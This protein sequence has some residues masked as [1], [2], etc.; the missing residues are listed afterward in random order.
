[1]PLPAALGTLPGILGGD[2]GRHPPATAW[3]GVK[4]GRLIA[5]GVLC[6]DASRLIDGVPDGICWCLGG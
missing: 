5:G 1:V 2:F 6:G 3:G 4:L